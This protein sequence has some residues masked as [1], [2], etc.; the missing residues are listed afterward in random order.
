MLSR[1]PN[2]AWKYSKAWIAVK[3][4]P[5]SDRQRQ[6]AHGVALVALE[7]R[8]VRPGHRGAREQQDQRVHERQVE[9]RDDVHA[10]G[11][12]DA[13]GGLGAHRHLRR[14]GIERG[15]E[16]RPEEGGEEQHLR[17]DEQDHAVAQAELDHRG[18]VLARF[19]DDVAPP[20]VHH[21][22][23]DQEARRDDPP[24]DRLDDGLDVRAQHV[25][26]HAER[27]AEGQQEGADARPAPAT[28]WDRR[29]DR[30]AS[31]RAVG[32]CSSTLSGSVGGYAAE[33]GL[34]PLRLRLEEGVGERDG[35]DVV[36][37]PILVHVGIDEEDHGHVDRLARLQ[38][39]LGEAEALQL[40]E[41]AG[42]QARA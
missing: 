32:H 35:A 29:D 8:V 40:V 4:R 1:K 41:P 36:V 16:E 10:L 21:G 7:D 17:G 30:D 34:R 3:Q 28:G 27:R 20:P 42:R 31:V 24:L 38:Q 33:Q 2:G 15:I 19:D 25:G 18:V 9:R 39:L 6:A 13:A 22:E 26:M 14:A 5:S 23:D 37:A 12:P 11:R